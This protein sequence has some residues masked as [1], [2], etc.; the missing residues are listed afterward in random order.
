MKYFTY[1]L[2]PLIGL[3]IGWRTLVTDPV[4][5]VTSVHPTDINITENLYDVK[6]KVVNVVTP[7]PGQTLT[8]FGEVNQLS[9]LPIID[10]LKKLGSGTAPIYLLIHSP[11]GSV[12]DGAMV[13]SAMEASK[14]P[15][16]TV[17][18]GMCA[19]MAAMV[20]SY[21]SQRLMVDRAFLMYHPATLGVGYN[22]LDKTVS[23]VQFIQRYSGKMDAF[24]AKRAGITIE[25]YKQLASIELWLDGEDA[26]NNKFADKLVSVNVKLDVPIQSEE[27]H[28]R[29][30][31]L[32]DGKTQWNF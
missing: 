26:V 14:A 22:E 7:P 23:R 17:C 10:G 11:G 8:L 12:M 24:V 13:I 29:G 20:F 19:S 6:Q 3:F 30:F 31:E 2:I 28:T 1:T 21:G 27:R 32:K 5:N 16:Y 15:V 18:L 4:H 25:K 9:V